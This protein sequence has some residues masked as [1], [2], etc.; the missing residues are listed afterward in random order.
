MAQGKRGFDAFTR[1]RVHATAPGKAF[2][3]YA[4]TGVMPV[5][6]ASIQKLWASVR[7]ILD[8]AEQ[9]F[10]DFTAFETAWA[11]FERARV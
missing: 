8:A 2:V 3:G 9:G 6:E 7:V 4:M 11:A 5:L 10:P 1:G